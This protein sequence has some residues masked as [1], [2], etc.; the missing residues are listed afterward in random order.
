M[1]WNKHT[2]NSVSHNLKNE[3]TK[4]LEYTINAGSIPAALINLTNGRYKCYMH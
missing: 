1:M 3:R 4:Q 2:F